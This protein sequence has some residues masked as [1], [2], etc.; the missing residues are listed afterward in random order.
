MQEYEAVFLLRGALAISSRHT[1]SKAKNSMTKR[2]V[3]LFLACLFG[4]F[5]GAFATNGVSVAEWSI[6]KVGATAASPDQQQY[7]LT[8]Q[9]KTAL[10]SREMAYMK[11]AIDPEKEN[12]FKTIAIKAVLRDHNM[13]RGGPK[14]WGQFVDFD[15]RFSAWK[16]PKMNIYIFYQ[17]QKESLADEVMGDTAFVIDKA[18]ALEKPSKQP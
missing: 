7:R 3:T 6:K 11:V 18:L 15:I 8:L 12:Q 17:P 13:Y 1:D 9:V 5:S 2:I 16:N 4:S 14:A 10:E